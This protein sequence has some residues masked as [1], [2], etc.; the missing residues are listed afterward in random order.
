MTKQTEIL[1]SLLLACIQLFYRQEKH[2]SY[3]YA[4]VKAQRIK[5]LH[6][7]VCS[8]CLE[9]TGST[10]PK[11]GSTGFCTVPSVIFWPARLPVNPV[12]KSRVQ[13]FFENR[14][15]RIWVRLNRI[16]GRSSL[17]LST[18]VNRELPGGNRFNR[19]WVYFS[20]RLPAFGGS[21]IYPP[22]LSL[23]LHSLLP[24][25]RIL[26]WP[27]FK[28]EHSVHL[29]HPKSHLL[30]SFEGPLVWG[31]VNLTRCWFHL[32]SPILFIFWAHRKLNLVRICYSWNLVFLDG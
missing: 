2:R 4:N 27:T 20:Q 8:K 1:T 28:Q 14:F 21:F 32:D 10:R 26:D 22:T 12:R 15:N 29:S 6:H 16:W 30:Q 23:S 13:S 19:F 25:P 17:R 5:I 11:T 18:S 9:T 31:E 24:S 3:E 7:I